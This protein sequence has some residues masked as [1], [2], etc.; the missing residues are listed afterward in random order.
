MAARASQGTHSVTQSEPEAPGNTDAGA[1]EV[2]ACLS[3]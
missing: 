1:D 2:S 3:A